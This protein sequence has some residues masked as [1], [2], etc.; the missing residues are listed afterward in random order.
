MPTVLHGGH[1]DAYL[2]LIGLIV[3]LPYRLEDR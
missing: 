3:R 2:L 1:Y